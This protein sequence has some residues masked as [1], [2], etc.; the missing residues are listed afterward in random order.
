MEERA[1]G[2]G[3]GAGWGF[4]GSRVGFFAVDGDCLYYRGFQPRTLTN[5]FAPAKVLDENRLKGAGLLSGYF[6]CYAP[7]P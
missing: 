7:P 4:R 6:S 1:V 2:S 5:T 3:S